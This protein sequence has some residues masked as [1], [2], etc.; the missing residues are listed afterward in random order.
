V[1]AERLSVEIDGFTRHVVRALDVV[2]RENYP[3]RGEVV[4]LRAAEAALS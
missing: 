3:A 2:E 1:R 4:D